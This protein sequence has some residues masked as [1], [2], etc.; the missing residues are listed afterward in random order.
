MIPA[1]SVILIAEDSEDDRFL[2]SEAVRAAGIGSPFR[3]V[4]DGAQAVAY[5]SGTGAFTDRQKHP[6]AGLVILDF[7][8]PRMNGLEVLQWIRASAVRRTPVIIMSASSLPGDVERAYDNCVN[9]YLMKPSSLDALIV[10]MKAL[11][12]YW[13]AANEY[14][15]P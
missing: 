14:P 15:S 6:P 1:G 2:L 7:K 5:L 13:L 11:N 8:M 10:T 12:D 3:F 9:S 4:E